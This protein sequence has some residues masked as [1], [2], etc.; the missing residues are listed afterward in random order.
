MNAPFKLPTFRPASSLSTAENDTL[1]PEGARKRHAIK[2]IA[3]AVVA[4]AAVGYPAYKYF[5]PQ[6]FT[7][8][9]V[10]MDAENHAFGLLH[11][12]CAV[13]DKELLIE[14]AKTAF[15]GLDALTVNPDGSEPIIISPELALTQAQ[16]GALNANFKPLHLTN[17]PS[18]IYI[19]YHFIE[20]ARIFDV[21]LRKNNEGKW[22]I[23][24]AIVGAPETRQVPIL[25]AIA[26]GV[27]ET[28]RVTGETVKNNW[29]SAW[30]TIDDV[31][32]TVGLGDGHD[33]ARAAFKQ[34]QDAQ[35]KYEHERPH[36]Y[37][38]PIFTIDMDYVPGRVPNLLFYN[39]R[40]LD[41]AT[42]KITGHEIDRRMRN[43]ENFCFPV[44][45]N[46]GVRIDTGIG[47]S[48]IPKPLF[49][50]PYHFFTPEMAR[51]VEAARL[52]SG[53]GA[54]DGFIPAALKYIYKAALKDDGLNGYELGA[55]VVAARAEQRVLDE[56]AE[57]GLRGTSH[58]LLTRL[59]LREPDAHTAPN[60]IP[61]R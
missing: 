57:Q 51:K 59:G 46:H 4:S 40:T 32:D 54:K 18:D 31:L 56:E 15:G 61:G 38:E 20:N 8:A 43:D 60:A 1:S 23:S 33:T 22:R 2:T 30:A 47:E 11:R 50:Y 3:G 21:R 49:T 39:G 5:T 19:P 13:G 41:N 24:I 36:P 10:K 55:L 42:Y 25:K 6:P 29:Q 45:P 34:Q 17:C 16:S 37:A 9:L 14:P 48:G 26:D 52:L 27:S 53:S 28:A 58:K 12:T 44:I 35:E 7:M